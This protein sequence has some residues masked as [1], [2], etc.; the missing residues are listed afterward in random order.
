MSDLHLLHAGLAPI[1]VAFADE[2]L[3]TASLD[4]S[5]WF[6]EAAALDDWL[7]YRVESPHA[8]H[9]LAL[10]RGDLFTRDGT[11]VAS[12]AQQGLIRILDTPRRDTL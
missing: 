12:T 10:G 11:I 7:L 2:R 5:V 6:H 9:A 1:G 4:H 8:G 3:Q